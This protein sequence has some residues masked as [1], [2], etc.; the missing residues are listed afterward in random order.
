MSWE[1]FVLRFHKEF[2]PAIE[3]QQLVREFQDLSQTTESVAKIT[4]KFC[5]RALLVPK[6]VANEEMKNTRYHYMLKDEI[7]Y[8]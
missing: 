7:R 2:S 6:Y 8:F 4:T 3:V 5:E 1:Q